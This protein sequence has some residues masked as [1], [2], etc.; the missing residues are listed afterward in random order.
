MSVV[1]DPPKPLAS[2]RVEASKLSVVSVA[3]CSWLGSGVSLM[4]LLGLARL[5]IRP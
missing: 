1:I 4:D 3:G 2:R 5:E